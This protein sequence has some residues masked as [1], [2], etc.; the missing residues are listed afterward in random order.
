MRGVGLDLI[1][2]YFNQREQY[3]SYSNSKSEI[4]LQNMGVIQGSKNGPTFFDI[5][6]NDLNYL[7]DADECILFADD[8]CLTYVHSDIE[9]LINH[10][11]QRLSVILDWCRFN[12]LSINPSKSE[13][14]VVTNRNIDF[15]PMLCIG[16]EQIAHKQCVKYLG[17]QIDNALNFNEQLKLLKTKLSRLSGISYRL[18][19]YFNMSTAKKFYFAFVYSALIYGISAW[20]GSLHYSGVTPRLIRL[21]EKIVKN[22]F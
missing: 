6:S 10:V 1:K 20:G 17:L 14:M 3:V 19:S 8:T 5:Y 22:L 16:N 15:E 9:Y 13:F 11:G 2:S 18:S 4:L 12:K 7:C 21:Q